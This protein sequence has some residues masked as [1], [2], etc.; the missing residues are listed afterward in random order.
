LTRDVVY[1]TYYQ[2]HVVNISVILF[3]KLMPK[4]NSTVAIYL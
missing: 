1:S 2:K 3:L 4:S